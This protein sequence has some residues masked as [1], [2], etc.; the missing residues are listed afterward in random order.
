MR[1][2]ELLAPAKDLDSARAAVDHG[3]DA[4][5]MGGVGFG[6]RSG[7][8]NTV[9]QVAQA[10][11]YAHQYGVKLYATLNTLIY[12]DEIEQAREVAQQMVDAGVDAL[13]IQDMAYLR[14]GL[15]SSR[16]VEFHASTQMCNM[17]TEGVQFL[18]DVGFSR[19]VLER[20]LSLK[21]MAAIAM[22]APDIELEAFVH[23]AICVGY[24]GRCYLSRSLSSRSGNRGE[25]SQPCRLSYD[26]VDGVGEVVMRGKHLLS[27]SDLDL[28][29][30]LGEMLDLGVSS[31]KIEGRLKDISYTKNI[32]AYYR[33]ML[34]R[35]IEK[36][37]NLI[38]SSVGKSV[39]EFTPDP[40]K[41][42]TR[43]STTYLAC[44]KRFSSTKIAT[45]ETPK[46]MGKRIGVVVKKRGEQEIICR[47][48]TTLS[49][50]D[51]VSFI[52]NRGVVGAYVNG[53]QK[54]S[55]SEVAIRVS[56]T[57]EVRAGDP[58]YRNFDSAFEASLESSRT[59]RTIAVRA[60]VR[61]T[62]S[63]VEI[64]YTDERGVESTTTID[65]PLEMSQ[66]REL[67][68]A[69]IVESLRKCGA[70]IFECNEVDMSGWG[71]EFIPAGVVTNIRREMLEQ[72]RING[73]EIANQSP[74]NGFVEKEINYPTN[75][76]HPN[77]G[78]TNPLAKA[79]YREH[80]VE[81]IPQSI[82]SYSDFEGIK[83]MET[84]Y[85]IRAEIGECLR[86]G[87]KLSEP[88]YIV[89]GGVRYR[90]EFD[91]KEC[92]MAVVKCSI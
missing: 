75:E 38:R 6:A 73:L 25:C 71:G 40:T 72:L 27:V 53:V 20:N 30:K 43:G 63:G 64:S 85:C 4:I 90:L 56:S 45:L 76:L 67:A 92:H 1:A 28:S 80:G 83:V 2:I 48:N 44:T 58:L 55:D 11:E 49:N 35:E 46:A 42:F 36:R 50:G 54:L 79:F 88:L 68:E 91:C 32:V 89:R 34:D 57:L 41:S 77:V 9:A 78:V 84:S 29:T 24:S 70:T 19:V 14:M 7:A 16:G 62:E 74:C 26:L 17:T 8:T 12:S 37:G 65:T 3:A 86:Q 33:K 60:A 82:E 10:V 51:G 61:T 21:Q 18:Q 47:C 15:Q 59:R 23:G 87:S 66:N 13:I 22:A 52:T 5:Y 69:K 39:V 81:L 31:F